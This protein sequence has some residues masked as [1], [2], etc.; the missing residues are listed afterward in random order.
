MTRGTSSG[1]AN[2]W[3]PERSVAGNHNPWAIV[4]VIS[5]ATF[6]TVLDTSIVN[7]ALDHIAGD[8]S[9]SYDQATWVTTTFLAATAIVIPISGWLADVMGRKRYYMTS[10]AL[11]TLASL[12]CGIA[13]NLTV[14][15]L[16]RAIQG[17][18]GGGL[19]AVEQS[20]LADTFP[21]KKRGMAFAAYG[22]VIIVAPI[23]GPILGGWITDNASWRW[24][25]LINVP[26]GLLSLLLVRIFVDEPEA[27]KRARAAILQHGLKMDLV[28]LVL[29][30]LF[31]GCLDL[32]LDRGQI[33][34]WFSSPFITTTAVV[35][36]LSLILFIPWE[37]T[38][39]KPIV[40]VAMFARPNFAIASI[41]L[42]L[43]GMIL[44]GTTLFIP[45]LLQVVMGYTA[46]DAGLALT[47][48][49]VATVIVMPIIGFVSGRI[50]ARLL[51]G[52]GFVIQALALLYMSHLSTDMTF[53]NAALARMLQSIGLPFLFI[54]I[55]TV[56]Y[57]GLA[58]TESN[59]A[60]AMMNVARNLGGT[61][62]I[63][64][65][66][67]LLAQREQFHQARLVEMLNPLNPTYTAG[68]DH[69]TQGLLDRGQSAAN[70]SREA[71]AT[72]YG[73]VQQQAAML[74]FIDVFHVL[75]IVVILAMPLL[76]VM[77][78]PNGGG[79]KAHIE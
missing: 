34:D 52:T 14:L 27:L 58:P 22:M 66:Q 35:A 7:V 20:M 72:L 9:A 37:L 12:L 63:S 71:V 25:F 4:A 1:R 60:S 32:T 38:R 74:S 51:I 70:A 75:M 39:D 64:S 44:F 10:V 48:G 47:A 3:T 56:A 24:C 62:G 46:T 19:A 53:A 67:I 43:T 55:T 21:P 50:D 57:V 31:F 73:I 45:Q 41:F 42:M 33:D 28:G 13:P 29:V 79:I 61:V 17:A 16:A 59:Q 77:Q 23:F 36:A 8:L 6:M 69:L 26:I 78:G 65:V 2:G 5:I 30:A 15:I 49:G 11:F 18:A 68:I 54:P 76:L 40:P